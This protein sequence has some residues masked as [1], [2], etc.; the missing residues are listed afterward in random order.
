M[1]KEKIGMKNKKT[2]R[3]LRAFFPS[4]PAAGDVIFREKAMIMNMHTP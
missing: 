3:L 2:L 4:G 1:Q